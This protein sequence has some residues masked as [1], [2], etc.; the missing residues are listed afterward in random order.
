MRDAH[1]GR[2]HLHRGTWRSC[3][4]RAAFRR[5]SLLAAQRMGSCAC[6]RRRKLFSATR[7]PRRPAATL[8]RQELRQASSSEF[9]LRTFSAEEI[10]ELL[11]FVG[12]LEAPEHAYA[13][14]VES[15]LRGKE[16]R[17]SVGNAEVHGRPGVLRSL[18]EPKAVT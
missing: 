7:H 12:H 1:D 5:R 13:V 6:G 14:V 17:R 9:S 2:E 8:P 15:E 16:N 11:H 10:A 18:F 3:F 4:H